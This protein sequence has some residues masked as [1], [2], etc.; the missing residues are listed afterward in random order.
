MHRRQA[1]H[2]TVAAALAFTASRAHAFEYWTPT[3]RVTHPWTR[4]SADG[5]TEAV[6]CMKFD[7]VRTADRLIGAQTMVAERVVLA[8]PAAG[9]E[10]DFAI[11]AGRETLLT[12]Y[13]AHL[14]LVNLQMPL[15]LGRT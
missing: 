8:G 12:E 4:A 9:P 7:E 15:E 10:I 2:T 6:V 14:R 5:A 1:L 11:P 3:L 13:G